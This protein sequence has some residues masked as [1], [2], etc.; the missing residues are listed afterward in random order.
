MI[1]GDAACTLFELHGG[2]RLMVPRRAHEGTKLA[3]E[4]G[5]AAARALSADYGGAT[6]KVPLA[7]RWRALRLR[8]EG[9]SH[10]QIARRLCASESSVCNWLR[11]AKQGSAGA[12]AR[13]RASEQAE[14]IPEPC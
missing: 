13:R 2:T 14:E 4:L 11:A 5:V 6:I 1:G 9:L 8:G 12:E 7:K 3:R 10:A